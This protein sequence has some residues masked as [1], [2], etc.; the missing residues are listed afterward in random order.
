MSVPTA[1]LLCLTA[2]PISLQAG[3]GVNDFVELGISPT[4]A[5]KLEHVLAERARR[6]RPTR[7]QQGT[8]IYD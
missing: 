7:G 6:Q 1:S 4:T 5:P 2:P 8:G 3:L